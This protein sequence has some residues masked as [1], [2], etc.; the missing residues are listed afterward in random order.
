MNL[1]RKAL[2]TRSDG[3][4]GENVGESSVKNSENFGEIMLTGTQMEIV[5]RIEAD[6]QTW[7]GWGYLVIYE[8]EMLLSIRITWTL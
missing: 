2:P 4:V 1:F 6:D 7:V 8:K 3:D 5:Q